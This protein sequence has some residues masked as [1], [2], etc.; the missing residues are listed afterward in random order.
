MGSTDSHR[1][2]EVRGLIAPLA[3]IAERTDA[4]ILGVMHLAKST[5]RPAIY[6]AVGSIAGAAAARV[7]LTVAIDR[8]EVDPWPGR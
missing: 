5:Q 2:A 8:L 1:D 7:V 3:T 6:R 4:A